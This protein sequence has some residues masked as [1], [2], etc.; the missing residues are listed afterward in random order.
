M[1]NFIVIVILAMI[2]SLDAFSA[3]SLEKIDFNTV[4]KKGEV[5]INYSG[6][7]NEYPELKITKSTIQVYFPDSKVQSTFDKKVKFSSNK[8]DTRMQAQQISSNVSKIKLTFPFDIKKYENN[9]T[10]TLKNDK[11]ILLFPQI[12]ISDKEVPK[13]ISKIDSKKF[14]EDY[15]N[16]LLA[17]KGVES[18]L[19]NK[20]VD[21]IVKTTEVTTIKKK[22]F[23]DER[24]KQQDIVKTTLAAV[25]KST[26]TQGNNFSFAGYAGKFIGF[27]MLV[28]ALFYGVVGILKKGVISKG[29]LGFLNSTNL[30]EVISTTYISPKR[31]LLMVKAHNQVFLVGSTDN[32]I[33][34]ISEIND[35]PGIVKTGERELIGENFDTN[36]NTASLDELDKKIILKKDIMTST[37]E[38]KNEIVKFSDQIKMKVKKMKDIQQ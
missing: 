20:K 5:T 35:V 38:K 17:I 27:L 36:M 6:N 13:A 9:V 7:L 34:L 3:I 29:K 11:V 15:L 26:E 1:K 30:V 19:K 10:L 22:S 18:D 21:N 2:V 23:L 33:Q 16:N 28:I 14:D 25:K 31:S 37:P 32:G 24:E 12:K 4:N 8:N